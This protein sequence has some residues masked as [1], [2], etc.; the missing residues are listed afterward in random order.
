MELAWAMGHAVM[1]GTAAALLFALA[2]PAAQANW[3]S[4]LARAGKLGSDLPAAPKT[5]SFLKRQICVS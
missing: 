4:E 1:R 2:A 5:S 3:L